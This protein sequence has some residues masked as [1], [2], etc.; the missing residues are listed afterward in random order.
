MEQKDG[1]EKA[2]KGKHDNTYLGYNEPNHDP[3]SRFRMG[4]G[5]SNGIWCANYPGSRTQVPTS[6]E[7]QSMCLPFGEHDSAIT[8]GSC[9]GGRYLRW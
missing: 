1:A 2:R 9:D 5:T 8:A 7:A 4:G 6:T 3:Q